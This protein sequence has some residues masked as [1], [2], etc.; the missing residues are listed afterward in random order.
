MCTCRTWGA[1]GGLAGALKL[2]T[3]ELED[4]K[5]GRKNTSA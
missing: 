5:H 3:T 2:N 4:R 1:S